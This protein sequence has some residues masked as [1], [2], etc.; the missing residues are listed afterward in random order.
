MSLHA[1]TLRLMLKSVSPRARAARMKQFETLM[2]IRPGQRV[3]DL[4]GSTKIWKFVDTP[5]NVTVVNLESQRIDEFTYGA[6]RF[7]IVRGDATGLR[8]F[9][10]GSFDL[11]F[12]NSCIEH[13][14]GADQQ[15]A[16]AREVRRLAPSYF[17]QT[18]S[19][20]FPVEAHTGLPFWW[21]YPESVRRSMIQRWERQRPAYGAFIAGTRVLTR[22]TLEEL[23][24]DAEVH[25][26]RVL[27]L[28]KSHILYRK[29]PERPAYAQQ[30]T[31]SLALGGERASRGIAG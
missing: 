8:D 18:P 23:F 15:A 21:Y 20:H 25:A 27:G 12:S 30:P 28:V 13:V 3:I 6:H 24:P 11:V 22:P 9:P 14:G 2:Q 31:S 29:G 16:F 5:L 7:T 4:G 19:I 26:E 1:K 10:D 17:V